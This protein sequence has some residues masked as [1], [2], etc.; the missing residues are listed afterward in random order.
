VD[1]YI[2]RNHIVNNL[3]NKFEARIT[4][5]ENKFDRKL[6]ATK[7]SIL[8]E[9]QEAMFRVMKGIDGDKAPLREYL[10][11]VEECKKQNYQGPDCLKDET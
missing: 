7:L 6:W 4:A 10:K 8:S 2:G 3:E 5:S 9:L 1:N 11:R